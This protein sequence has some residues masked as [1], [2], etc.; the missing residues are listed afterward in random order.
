MPSSSFSGRRAEFGGEQGPTGERRSCVRESCVTPTERPAGAPAASNRADGRYRSGSPPTSAGRGASRFVDERITGLFQIA[1][2]E[3]GFSEDLQK[4]AWADGLFAVNRDHG[5]AAVWVFEEVVTTPYS[6]D[7]EALSFEP[8]DQLPACD[9]WE[10]GH[11]PTVTVWTP[12]K[13]RGSG[14]SLVVSRNN[15][16]AS[17][18]R[19]INSSRDLAWV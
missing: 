13:S 10:A 1:S 6:H 5:G 14:G 18:I 12:T 16:I 8:R 3:L 9:S 19:T 7:L 15:S 11:S 17:R 2:V 4:Q